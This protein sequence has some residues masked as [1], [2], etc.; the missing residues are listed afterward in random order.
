M[1]TLRSFLGI[2]WQDRIIN[3]EIQDRAESLS[4]EAI[5]CS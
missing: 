2:R 4:I 1:R 3:L 5:I